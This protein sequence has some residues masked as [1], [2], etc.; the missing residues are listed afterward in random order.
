MCPGGGCGGGDGLCFP[1]ARGTGRRQP[2]T[3]P[4]PAHRHDHCRR[5]HQPG[6]PAPDRRHGREVHPRPGCLRLPSLRRPDPPGRQAQERHAPQGPLADAGSAG[7]G[8]DHRRRLRAD[9]AHGGPDADEPPG[10]LRRTP[11]AGADPLRP[12]RAA[13]QGRRSA[14]A[15]P[16]GV[17]RQGPEP[18]LPRQG[19]RQG[20]PVRPGRP[21]PARHRGGL[22]GHA[23]PRPGVDL[24]PL[25]RRHHDRG[26]QGAD[27]PAASSGRSRCG[28]RGP[29]WSTSCWTWPAR[30]RSS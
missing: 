26:Q 30:P 5:P 20:R 7:D 13:R 23:L 6:L 10:H 2:S 25:G 29:T 22:A 12:R 16:Q 19:G 27:R 17:R 4:G 18:V 15:A 28:T 3:G 1:V 21:H 24:V 14:G 8:M 11:R 9:P